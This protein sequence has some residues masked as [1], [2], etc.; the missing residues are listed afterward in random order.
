MKRKII[1]IIFLV[2]LN[3]FAEVDEP[4]VIRLSDYAKKKI[5]IAIT[6]FQGS[7]E[8]SAHLTDADRINLS[9]I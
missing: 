5:P 1:F 2:S 3:A 4:F 9:L 8:D 7:G 6:E